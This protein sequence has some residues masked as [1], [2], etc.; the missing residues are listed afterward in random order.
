M[1]VALPNKCEGDQ[2]RLKLVLVYLIKQALKQA[3]EGQIWLSALFNVE[4]D[5]LQAKITQIN[6]V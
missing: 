1:L 4:D 3:N 5:Q 2:I 6:P